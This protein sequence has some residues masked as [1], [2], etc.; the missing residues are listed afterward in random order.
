MLALSKHIYS[1]E[2]KMHTITYLPTAFEY[3]SAIHL[4]RLY[5]KPF[6]VYQDVCA[7]KKSTFKFPLQDKGID[8]I[9]EQFQH[10][11]QVKYYKEYSKIYYGK[12]AT[13]L[14]TPLLVGK[15]LEMTLVRTNH[16]FLHSDIK[17]II[18]RK[19]LNDI[20]LCTKD[21]VNTKYGI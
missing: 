2:R 15:K 4:T 5:R 7:L 18:D 20:Q 21:F 17:R 3:Y 12:L 16:C 11:A 19:D 1:L 9:D 13:F 14:A 6:F 8:I 10:I